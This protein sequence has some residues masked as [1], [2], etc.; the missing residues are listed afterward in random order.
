MAIELMEA[1]LRF[2]RQVPIP[3]IYKGHQTEHAFR[4]DLV[5]EETLIV[6]I[7][8]LDRLAPVHDAQ[9]LTYLSVGGFPV[10]LLINFNVPK[11]VDGVKR[12]VS[13]AWRT[14]DESDATRTADAM[15]AYALSPSRCAAAH[16]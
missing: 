8:S 13:S 1:G 15:S 6:E 10:G 7:K 9:V 4:A 5:I 3:A 14:E 12:Y 11:L 16:L 2:Q